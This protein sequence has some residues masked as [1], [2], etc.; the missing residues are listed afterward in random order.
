MAPVT[1][2]ANT[3][4]SYLALG[5]ALLGVFPA[6]WLLYPWLWRLEGLVLCPFR[7]VTGLR[8]PFCGLTRA[9]ACA[10]RGEWGRAWGFHPLWPAAALTLVL[11]GV[12]CLWRAWAPARGVGGRKWWVVKDSN[13]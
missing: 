7:L 12:W 5:L 2:M 11:A 6:A 13:L 1:E 10:I 4:L 9:L 3:R 8:C